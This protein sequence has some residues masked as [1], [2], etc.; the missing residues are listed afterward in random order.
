MSKTPVVGSVDAK[1]RV[2]SHLSKVPL[3]GT[4][5]FTANLIELS[6][7]VI[8]KTG[9][10]ARLTDGNTAD[11]KRIRIATRMLLSLCLLNIDFP[12]GCPES[13]PPNAIC[14]VLHRKLAKLPGCNRNRL[15]L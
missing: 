1:V 10:C 8:L 9:T 3:T 11:A 14:T 6:S 15:N 7:V 4:D 12:T 13:G 2:A 5:A